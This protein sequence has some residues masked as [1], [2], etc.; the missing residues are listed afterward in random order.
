MDKEDF[1][2]DEDNFDDFLDGRLINEV[3]D[4]ELEKILQ[5]EE[6]PEEKKEGEETTI[7]K[8]NT[9]ENAASN[10][11]EDKQ[12]DNNNG[13]E[14]EENIDETST[15]KPIEYKWDFIENEPSALYQDIIKQIITSTASK[16]PTQQATKKASS[17]EYKQQ[18]LEDINL[19]TQVVETRIS[20]LISNLLNQFGRVMTIPSLEEL[21]TRQEGVTSQSPSFEKL[22]PSL[23]RKIT[24]LECTLEHLTE[25]FQSSV[26]EQ[27]KLVKSKKAAR[28]K[29]EQELLKRKDAYNKLKSKYTTLLTKAKKLQLTSRKYKELVLKHDPEAL[30]KEDGFDTDVVVD[31]KDESF[32]TLPSNQEGVMANIKA[33]T[34]NTNWSFWKDK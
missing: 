9:T 19:E 8:S 11:K 13:E 29:Y 7:E 23:Q 17:P 20:F 16:K 6:I 27:A 24:L 18:K 34:E 33:W 32:T 5:E 30:A 28:Q 25:G 31:S 10:E 22:R 12:K 3:E 21:H 2:E 1:L 15:F 4:E 26:N 14:E